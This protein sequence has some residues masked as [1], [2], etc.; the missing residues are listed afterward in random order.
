[1]EEDRMGD[2]RTAAG[3]ARRTAR[4]LATIGLS[5]LVALTGLPML[6]AAAAAPPSVSVD[7][8]TVTEGAAGSTVIARFTL[9]M[10]APTRKPVGV[11][12]TTQDDTATA[13]SDYVMLS[14]TA[15]IKKGSTTKKVAITVNGDDL[16]EGDEAFVV[17]LKSAHGASIGDGNGIGTIV[18]DDPLPSISISNASVLEGTGGTT[19]LSFDVRLDRKLGSDVTVDYAST[20]DTA[21]DP[22]DYTAV[23]GTLT[24]PAGT[25]GVQS[26]SVDVQGDSADEP[27]ETFTI[28][29]SNETGGATIAR[30]TAT[31]IILDD[32]LPN[33]PPPTPDPSTTTLKVAKR[34]TKTLAIGAVTP[35]H[36]G[37]TVTVTLYKRKSGHWAI[38]ATKHPILGTATDK[39]GD[40]IYSSPY[41]ATFKRLRGRQKIVVR[42]AGDVDHQA[43]SASKKFKR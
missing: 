26:V 2:T 11:N 19:P 4:R 20:D 41:K 21:T 6:H 34:R 31:G 23:S 10:T 43:S 37:L 40:G 17:H 15:T 32:D 18:D 22:G 3:T 38:V 8:V 16:Y 35:A 30:A 7:D 39:D 27:D 5:A 29:L 9:T 13:G 24:W 14:G 36:T 25:D 12:F 33:P 28:T 42:F 1:L